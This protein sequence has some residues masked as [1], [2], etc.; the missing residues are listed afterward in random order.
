MFESAQRACPT[1]VDGYPVHE[2]AL[3]TALFID[4]DVSSATMK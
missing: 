3:P 4:P 1:R 2:G